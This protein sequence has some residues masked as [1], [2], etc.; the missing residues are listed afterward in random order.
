[1]KYYFKQKQ[2]FKKKHTGALVIYILKK[3]NSN[4]LIQGLYRLEKYLNI[5]D[6]LEKSLKIEIA[7]KGTW[8]TLKGLEK[9]LNFTICKIQH[10]FWI[11]NQYQIVVPSFGAA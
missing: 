3:G 5:Q 1:M 11:L 6:C 9:S 10:S 2:R 8:K 4:Y 7:L